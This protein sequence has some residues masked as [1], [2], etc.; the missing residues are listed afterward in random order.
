[1]RAAS[2]ISTWGNTSLPDFLRLT[3]LPQN[4]PDMPWWVEG[5]LDWLLRV[6]AIQEGWGN[7][8][9]AARYKLEVALGGPPLHGYAAGPEAVYSIYSDMVQMQEAEKNSR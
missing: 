3:G 9:E 2:L 1:M 7:A 5:I 6:K 4:Q 8:G